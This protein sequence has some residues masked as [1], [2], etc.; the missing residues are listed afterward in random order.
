MQQKDHKLHSHVSQKRFILND[1][2]VFKLFALQTCKVFVSFYP[3]R[4]IELFINNNNNKKSAAE[5]ILMIRLIKQ[6]K[7]CLL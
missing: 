3:I 7:V 6:D 1:T 5:G 4:K 2:L